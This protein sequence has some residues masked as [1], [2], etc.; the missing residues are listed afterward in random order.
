MDPSG[1]YPSGTESKAPSGRGKTKEEEAMNLKKWNVMALVLMPSGRIVDHV[2]MSEH[3]TLAGARK[4]I[5][6]YELL[7]NPN[8]LLDVVYTVARV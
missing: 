2:K 1:T 3:I 5:A 4:A 8:E 7:D 6:K